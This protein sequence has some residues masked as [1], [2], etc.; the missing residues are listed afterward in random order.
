LFLNP[1]GGGGGGAYLQEIISNCKN[2]YIHDSHMLMTWLEMK[3]EKKHKKNM[4]KM[5]K[6]NL[7]WASARKRGV[8]YVKNCIMH[9]VFS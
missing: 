1:L 6:A 2:I 5:E 9:G 7:A 8:L 3:K 4:E